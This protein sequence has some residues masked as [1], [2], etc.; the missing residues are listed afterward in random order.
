[1]PD[2]AANRLVER[3]LK[4]TRVFDAPQRV[5][6]KAWIDPEQL[7]RW[8]G[9]RGF[10]NPLCEVDARPGGTIRIIMRAPDGVSHEMR[11]VFREINEPERL[12]FTNRAIG[13]KGELLLEGLTTVSFSDHEGKTTL[14]LDTSAVAMLP[15]ANAMLNGMNDGWNQSLERLTMV[16]AG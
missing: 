13:P 8:W 16:L 10:T 9:P 12:V 3:K 11:G 14:T 4:I 15:E 1:M 5:V 6:F 2:N 7:A